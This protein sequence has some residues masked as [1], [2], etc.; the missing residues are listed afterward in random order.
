MRQMRETEKETETERDREIEIEERDGD[1]WY[2]CCEELPPVH[3]ISGRAKAISKV[4][5][6]RQAGGRRHGDR[7]G[8]GARGTLIAD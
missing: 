1:A 5:R 2:H 8:S 3:A 4:P 6:R 7:H